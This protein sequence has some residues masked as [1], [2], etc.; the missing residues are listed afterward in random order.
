MENQN[1]KTIQIDGVNFEYNEE[2]DNLFFCTA[3]HT[4]KLRQ[5]TA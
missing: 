3:D 5:G 1:I 2:Q 4:D